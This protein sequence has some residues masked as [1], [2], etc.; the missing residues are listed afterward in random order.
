MGNRKSSPQVD[1][2]GD[3]A[4]TVITT[5]EL[6]TDLH[7]SHAIKLWIVIILQSVQ[8]IWVILKWYQS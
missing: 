8:I 7:E 1:T 2:Q 5:Q 4:V 3:H 6:H